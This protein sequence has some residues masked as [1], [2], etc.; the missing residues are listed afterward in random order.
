MLYKID[1]RKL[2]KSPQSLV[3]ILFAC[4]EYDSSSPYFEAIRPYLAPSTADEKWEEIIFN[5]NF[6]FNHLEYEDRKDR[7]VKIASKYI[8]LPDIT[9][10]HDIADA[11]CMILYEIQKNQL[12]FKRVE[13]LKRLP[14]DNYRFN[15][16]N[17]V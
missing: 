1:P 8:T 12:K 15:A 4:F 6:R 5:L 14:F 9:R 7:V 10:Q 17:M 11:F 3:P 2:A 13:E 16:N